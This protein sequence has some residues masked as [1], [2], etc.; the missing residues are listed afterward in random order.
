MSVGQNLL[1]QLQNIEP[2]GRLVIDLEKIIASDN[3]DDF[4]IELRDG[5]ILMVPHRSQEVMVL[6]EVQYATSHLFGEGMSRDDYIGLS[7][8]LTANSDPKRVYVV[9][10]N[11]AVEAPDLLT[12]LSVWGLDPGGPPDFDGDGV[13]A[14]P[15]LLTLLAAWGPCP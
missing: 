14:V 2:T 4:D 15:D 10:A 3:G 9:R 8:G 13:V 7:G 12:L 6:G 11:G 5:D 1:T